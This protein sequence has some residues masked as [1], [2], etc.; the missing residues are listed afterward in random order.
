MLQVEG[1]DKS[2]AGFQ[3]LSEAR[4][5]VH[6]GSIVA[7]IGPNGAGKTTL[8]NVITGHLHPDEGRV[9]FKGEDITGV[10][11]HRICHRGIS[12]SFQLINIFEGLSVWENVQVSVLSRRGMILRAF[13]SSRGLVQEETQQILEKVG[14]A[15]KMS[16]PSVS[17]SHGDKKVLEIA[18]ALGNTPELLLLDEPTA[19]MSPEETRTVIDLCRE[20][21]EKEGLTI[22]FTEHDIDMVFDIADEIM[23]LH[24]GRT[25][26]QDYPQEVRRNERV[27]GAYLGETC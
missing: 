17:L 12:R 9:L 13:A 19:G 10:A 22:L 1:I 3:A 23:V 7:V 27:Q 11:P 25:L 4:L 15:D 26:T 21:A 14:L 18:I 8:F 5:H 16:A 20:L 24:Q 2:F 6:P